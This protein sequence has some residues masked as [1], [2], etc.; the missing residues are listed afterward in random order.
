MKNKTLCEYEEEIIE[1]T[2]NEVIAIRSAV[3]GTPVSRQTSG[4]S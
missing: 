3:F 4:V 2:G 1:C